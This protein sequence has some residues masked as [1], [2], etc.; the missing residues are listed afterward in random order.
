MRSWC[1]TAGTKHSGEDAE[2][3]VRDVHTGRRR[4]VRLRFA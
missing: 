3:T 1:E 4:T 2:L